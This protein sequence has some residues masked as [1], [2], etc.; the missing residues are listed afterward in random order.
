MVFLDRPQNNF[1]SLLYCEKKTLILQA[2]IL[3]KEEDLCT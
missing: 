2:E 1:H 3:S